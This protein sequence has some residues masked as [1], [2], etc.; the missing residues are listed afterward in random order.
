MKQCFVILWFGGK[1][2]ESTTTN[3]ARILFLMTRAAA[4]AVGKR[5]R[6]YLLHNSYHTIARRNNKTHKNG[7]KNLCAV[8]SYTRREER[9][10]KHL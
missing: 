1:E 2:E 4:A 3:I 5:S 10:K 8:F 7:F 6:E 9:E